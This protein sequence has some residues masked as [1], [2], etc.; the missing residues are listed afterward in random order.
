MSVLDHLASAL[1]RGD[2]LPNQELAKK[3]ADDQD[4]AGVRVLVDHLASEDPAIQSD[5]IK[6]LYEIGY[7]DPALIDGYW[8]A[9]LALLES[10]NNRMVW[11]G[12]TALA[13]IASLRADDLFPRVKRIQD[14]VDWG[15]VITQDGGIKVLAAI[16]AQR[17]DARQALLPT[18]LD[19]LQSCRP[20]D[21]PRQAEAVEPAV[22]DDHRQQFLGLLN[23]R[24][25][26]LKESQ[27]K[28]LKKVM[29]QASQG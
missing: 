24:L 6:T 20:K 8:E 11:G 3:L 16:A 26:E 1:R 28:R 18:L 2:D 9:F 22:D 10:K 7:L 17:A 15:S 13:T 4:H 14:A 27:F 12:M 29:N 5:C 25:P 21:L 23:S 19:F